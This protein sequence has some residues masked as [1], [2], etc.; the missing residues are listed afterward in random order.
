MKIFAIHL[1]FFT[2]KIFIHLGICICTHTCT[3]REKEEMCIN[4][5]RKRVKELEKAKKL[6]KAKRR[7]IWKGLEEG[8]KRKC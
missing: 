3:D 4:R 7:I 2:T 1:L 6:E 8:K 5:E